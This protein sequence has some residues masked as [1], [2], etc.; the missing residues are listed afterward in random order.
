MPEYIWT[1]F[2]LPNTVMYEIHCQIQRSFLPFSTNIT[3][4]MRF[5]NIVTR[6]I[7]TKRMLFIDSDT[8]LSVWTVTKWPL[9]SH[10]DNSVLKSDLKTNL[11]I[12][13]LQA[14][15]DNIPWIAMQI[16]TIKVGYKMFVLIGLIGP[17]TWF[18]GSSFHY[19]NVILLFLFRSWRKA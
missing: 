3:C 4:S 5:L 2:S 13:S 8:I 6:F 15:K 19:E 12:S 9:S 14:F 16:I 10:R 11:I 18:L 7:G 17:R 1:F